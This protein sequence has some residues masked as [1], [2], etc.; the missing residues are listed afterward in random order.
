M[1]LKH[2]LFS[3]QNSDGNLAIV[4]D[5]Q[6]FRE[7]TWQPHTE[8]I[9]SCRKPS[10][11]EPRH[12]AIILLLPQV[13]NGVAYSFFRVE[14]RTQPDQTPRRTTMNFKQLED[15]FTSSDDFRV[16]EIPPTRKRTLAT[17]D[18]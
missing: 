4:I 6:G 17:Y 7:V 2:R 15:L 13:Y 16:R 1:I 10:L 8:L 3:S 12:T 11:R 18:N 9:L 5:M 14:Y